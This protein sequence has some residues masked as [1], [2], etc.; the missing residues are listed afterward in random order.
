MH[1]HVSREQQVAKLYVAE[2]PGGRSKWGRRRG[3]PRWSKR[4]PRAGPQQT[5]EGLSYRITEGWNTEISFFRSPL[6]LFWLE[7]G[8]LVGERHVE[9]GVRQQ[10][11]RKEAPGRA[12]RSPATVQAT[13][14]CARWS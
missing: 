4:D 6:G 12:S 13:E 1:A 14:M 9:I 11:L 8:C 5:R 10:T 7:K 3:P 2:L